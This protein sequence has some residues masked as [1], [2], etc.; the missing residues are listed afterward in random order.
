MDKS[1]IIQ[2]LETEFQPVTLATP[3]ATM[4]QIVSNAYR[5]WN[6]N[7]GFK[8][9]RVYPI[10]EIG[11]GTGAQAGMVEVDLDMKNVVRVFPTTRAESIFQSY[12]MWTLLGLQV[13]DNITSD[14]IIMAEGLRSYRVYASANFMWRFQRPESPLNKGKLMVKNLPSGVTE[15][16]VEGTKRLVEGED[17]VNEYILDWILRYSKCL[18]KMI[19]GNA[20]RKSDII[21]VKNDGQVLYEEGKAEQAELEKYLATSGRWVA[22]AQRF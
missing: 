2:W 21:G 19:E 11:G 3:H 13:M 9:V 5:Y 22:L 7:N 17:I 10:S 1:A 4:D 12:P 18:L 20:L 15:V 16:S 14:L 8:I 6:T